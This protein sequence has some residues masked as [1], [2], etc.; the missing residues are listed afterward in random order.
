MP[1][2]IKQIVDEEIE[3]P[4]YPLQVSIQYSYSRLSNSR[5]LSNK[6]SLGNFPEINKRSL[7]NNCSLGKEFQK[8]N[9]HSPFDQ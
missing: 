3:L 4:G 7:L 8:V 6:R 2:I 1:D 9:K 5:R